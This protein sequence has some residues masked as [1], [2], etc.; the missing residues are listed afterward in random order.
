MCISFAD[1]VALLPDKYVCPELKTWGPLV[2]KDSRH[3]VLG[4]VAFQHTTKPVVAND[5]MIDEV[6]SF[7]LIT[8]PNGAGKV[9]N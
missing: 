3:P 1:V 7:V 8:G 2:V 5:I 4:E 6:E 9:G